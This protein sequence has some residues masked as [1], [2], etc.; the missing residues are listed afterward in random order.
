VKPPALEECHAKECIS[1]LFGWPNLVQNDLD[2]I[3]RHAN[4]TQPQLL[5]Q[6]GW[7]HD[8]QNW[9][10]WGPGSAQYFTLNESDLAAGR[11]GLAE[12]EVQSS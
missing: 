3:F 11:F 8:G 6:I 2:S 9:E 7:Y 10:S 4:Y 5:I 12:L 1:K